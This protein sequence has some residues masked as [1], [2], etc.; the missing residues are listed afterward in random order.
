V[1]LSPPARPIDKQSREPFLDESTAPQANGGA[2]HAEHGGNG[3]RSVATSREQDDAAAPDHTMRRCL[4]VREAL[5][6]SVSVRGYRGSNAVDCACDWSRQPVCRTKWK[7]ISR[8]SAERRCSVGGEPAD[9]VCEERTKVF[10]E[11][12]VLHVQAPLTMY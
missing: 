10:L 6:S 7:G 11:R 4:T 5:Q 2:A 9:A 12:V 3:D 1:L 8:R